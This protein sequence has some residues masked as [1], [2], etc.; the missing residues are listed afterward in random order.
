MN[1]TMRTILVFVLLVGAVV[2][3]SI[4]YRRSASGTATGSAGAGAAAQTVDEGSLHPELKLALDAVGEDREQDAIRHF[5]AV[6]PDSPGYSTA[7]RHLAILAARQGDYDDS[8]ASLLQL[9]TQRPDDPEV[10]ASLGWVFYLAEH[11][12]D[13]EHAALRALE[14]DATHVATRFNIG[15]Y[16]IAQGRAQ[17]AI[18]S[19][20]RAMRADLLP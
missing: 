16:R 4:V 17:L 1:A 7:L 15:L 14:L 3:A 11:Y 12:N 13:A 8:I 6:P 5:R 19:Y 18:S 2:V 20:I 10:H 9:T